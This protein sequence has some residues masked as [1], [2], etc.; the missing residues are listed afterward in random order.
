M[1]ELI[2]A[3]AAADGIESG[4]SLTLIWGS[5]A[6]ESALARLCVSASLRWLICKEICW[7]FIDGFGLG[8]SRE[9]EGVCKRDS[10]TKSECR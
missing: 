3:A 6:T 4:S 2:P 7:E 8:V 10:G 9:E 5:T 1:A